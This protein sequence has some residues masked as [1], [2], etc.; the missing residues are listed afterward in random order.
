MIHIDTHEGNSE[1]KTRYM[2]ISNRLR[3]CYISWKQKLVHVSEKQNHLCLKCACQTESK[4]LLLKTTPKQSS[5]MEK[6]CWG[7]P[8]AF[9]P[10][11]QCSLCQKLLCM[12]PRAQLQTLQSTIANIQ[13][14]TVVYRGGIAH[15]VL[16]HQYL[17]L[18][19]NSI[20]KMGPIPQIAQVPRT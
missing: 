4:L 20:C 1:T 10:T 14:D 8:R 12:L 15:V 7:L 18:F 13:P 3:L 5:K 2:K 17:T 19:L 11:D 6:L 16:T 9:I